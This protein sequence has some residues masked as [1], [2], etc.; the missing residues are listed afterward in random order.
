MT[1]LALHRLYNLLMQELEASGVLTRAFSFLSKRCWMSRWRRVSLLTCW[2]FLPR[3]WEHSIHKN[4]TFC[5]P[6]ASGWTGQ[7]FSTFNF[8]R[9]ALTILAHFSVYVI[10][11]SL[12]A[13][14]IL[15]C[16]AQPPKLQAYTHPSLISVA[17]IK[18]PW[19]KATLGKER[20]I[21]LEIPGYTPSL[22]GS[23]GKNLQHHSYSQT[24][25]ENKH[26]YIY[27]ACS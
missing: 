17:V 16:T 4:T 19:P 11:S 12:G 5:S 10:F 25:R 2:Y 8:Y 23:Q 15:H 1:V 6:L 3:G 22:Q 18:M 13:L 20:F 24:Q 14:Q 21:L 27:F 9:V 7:C 26:T